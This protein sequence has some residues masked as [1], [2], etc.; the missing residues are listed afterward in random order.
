MAKSKDKQRSS[1][2]RKLEKEEEEEI[3]DEQPIHDE[4]VTEESIEVN[5]ED[6]PQ[7]D[8]NSTSSDSSS[9]TASDVSEE[10][11]D[12]GSDSEED[13]IATEQQQQAQQKVHLS[14]AVCILTFSEPQQMNPVKIDLE[15]ITWNYSPLNLAMK[16]IC[17]GRYLLGFKLGGC[18]DL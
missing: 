18:A 9:S 12:D 17:Y 14:H 11:S 16:S 3:Q 8:D 15:N 7:D 10:S 4:P 2:K 6:K 1:K 5:M 13:D